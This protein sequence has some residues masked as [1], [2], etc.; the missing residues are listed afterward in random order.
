MRQEAPVGPVRVRKV[1]E[2][3]LLAAPQREVV[4]AA[5]KTPRV[6]PVEGQRELGTLERGS[7]T[8]PPR[9]RLHV[10]EHRPE[11][12]PAGVLGTPFGIPFGTRGH[13]PS[14]HARGPVGDAP[15]E[16]R[17]P[18]ALHR[19]QRPLQQLGRFGPLS[20]VVVHVR[21]REQRVDVPRP[22]LQQRVQ[23]VRIVRRHRAL[24]RGV[25]VGA[26]C[27]ADEP[28]RLQMTLHPDALHRQPDA[29]GPQRRPRILG[30]DE[31]GP[32]RGPRRGRELG[33]LVGLPTPRVP[34]DV[35]EP[36]LPSQA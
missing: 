25:G 8:T 16:P 14:V 26:S 13:H 27:V 10:L 1:Q 18:R 31:R 9:E 33:A 19:V 2:P 22:V 3:V 17:V 6:G 11:E 28:K 12:Q 20:G 36:L 29:L 34:A 15:R 32:R 7:V 21:Q 30:L 4:H 24:V 5:Q 23:V 35:R